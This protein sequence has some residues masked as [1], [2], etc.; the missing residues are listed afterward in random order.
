MK[1][2]IRDVIIGLA[3]LG[4][5][6]WLVLSA[7]SQPPFSPTPIV[8][9]EAE[10]ETY[11]PLQPF[12]NIG[13]IPS[14][15]PKAQPGS[16][17]EPF[18][19]LQGLNPPATSQTVPQNPLQQFGKLNGLNPPTQI[20]Q[21]GNPLQMFE[22]MQNLNAPNRISTPG[23]PTVPFGQF[24]SIPTPNPYAKP[25]DPTQPFSQLSGMNPPNSMY[26]SFMLSDFSGGL[27]RMDLPAQIADN[28]ATELVNFIWDGKKLGPR[29]GFTW[30]NTGEFDAGERIYGLY[31]YYKQNGGS[32][33]LVGID[34]TL[35]ADTNTLIEGRGKDFW[36]IK[37]GLQSN[38]A[39]YY[40]ET[41]KDKVIVAHKADSP[42]IL[43]SGLSEVIEFGVLDSFTTDFH[44]ADACT[45]FYT[46]EGEDWSEDEWAGHFLSAQRTPHQGTSTDR[47]PLLISSNTANVL[48]VHSYSGVYYTLGKQYYIWGFFGYDTVAT[49]LRSEGLVVL[50][51]CAVSIYNSGDVFDTSMEGKCIVAKYYTGAATNSEFPVYDVPDAHHLVLQ[52]P[53]DPEPAFGDSFNLLQKVI[54]K[55]DI[56][57]RYKNYLFCVDTDNDIIYFSPYDKCGGFGLDNYFFVRSIRGDHVTALS[58]FYDDQLGYKDDSKDCLVIFKNNSIYKLIFNSDTDY[59][60]VQVVDGVGCVAPQTVVNVEGKYLLFLHTSGVYAF[61]GRTVTRVSDKMWPLFET[62][63]RKTSI[64]VAAAG[65]NDRHYYLSYP[66]GASYN[67]EGFVFNTDLGSWAET[68]NLTGN[69]FCQQ[70]AVSDTVKL[71]FADSRAKSFIYRF[72]KVVTDTGEAILVS[73]KSKAFNLGD[74]HTRKRFTYFD[75]DYYLDSDSIWT[76]F[77]TDFGDSLKYDKKVGGA[78]GNRHIRIPLDA[79]C[80]G[81]NFS[82]KLAC[83]NK[84][85]IG[86]IALK[87]R[88]IGE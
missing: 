48:T 68:G 1:Q 71:L 50:D 34:G 28:E 13:Q 25:G 84:F 52:Y 24:N 46:A 6:A 38:G 27:N 81:R 12:G 29:P 9:T 82:F 61:D 88:Q 75:M 2:K 20:N 43:D 57:Q 37:T 54:S 74:L 7:Q 56:C 51:T 11:S 5:V 36:T 63:V 21:P 78:G 70:N 85:E 35:Y 76:W 45:I 40:F 3:I 60:L 16:P 66:A 47:V 10:E 33:L 53:P 17:L 80:I 32:A 77:Y 86:N 73:L 26:Q 55:V 22:K 72:G 8:D 62:N 15:V 64:G 39:Y 67:T 65:Y 49:G 44:Y 31:R 19:T 58:T 18:G 23:N 30:Y 59:Y 4:C 69:L 42:F 79:D 83:E 41:L 87:F 14:P